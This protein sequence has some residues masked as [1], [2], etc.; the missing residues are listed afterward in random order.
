MA[1]DVHRNLNRMVSH[2]LLHINDRCSALN[3]Q[4]PKGMPEIV[5]SDSAEAGMF[6]GRQ[7]IAVIEVFRLK[8]RPRLR[9][10]NKVISDAV[11]PAQK[12]L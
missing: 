5:E 8:D 10:E 3:Q 6:Q 11:F 1:I 4:G 2:L 9:R 12:R 7:E